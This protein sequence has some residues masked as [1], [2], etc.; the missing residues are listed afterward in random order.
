MKAILIIFFF[1]FS[2][3]AFSQLD[4]GRYESPCATLNLKKNKRFKYTDDHRQCYATTIYIGNYTF[5]SDTLVLMDTVD[6]KYNI[7]RNAFYVAKQGKLIFI[8]DT[9]FNTNSKAYLISI[10]EFKKEHN[11]PKESVIL[12]GS[13]KKCGDFVSKPLK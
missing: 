5:R 11:I 6:A 10:E 1:L 13:F 9:F 7:I 12:P 3:L 4:S 2:G 8:R